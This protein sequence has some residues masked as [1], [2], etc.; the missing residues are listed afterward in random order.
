MNAQPSVI[1]SGGVI[2][3]ENEAVLESTYGRVTN[4]PP[5]LR[6]DDGLSMGLSFRS[7]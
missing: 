2:T 1:N 4:A 7:G 3:I 6:I 5:L